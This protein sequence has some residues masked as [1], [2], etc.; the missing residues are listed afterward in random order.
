MDTE[1]W[2]STLLILGP[3]NTV[4]HVVMIPQPVKLLVLQLHNCHSAIVTNHNVT[5]C[6]F[7]WS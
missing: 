2:F 4:P 3:F 7:Q 6:V 1:Q 5:I